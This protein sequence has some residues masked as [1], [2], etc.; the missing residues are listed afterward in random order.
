[1]K[2]DV[3]IID[4]FI[5]FKVLNSLQINL[6]SD[7]KFLRLGSAPWFKF[8]SESLASEPKSQFETSNPV[9]YNHFNISSL[10][11][12]KEIKFLLYL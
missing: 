7:N 4:Y 10:P 5:P 11:V 2:Q 3:S 1:M 9:L 12:M 6:S 8:S